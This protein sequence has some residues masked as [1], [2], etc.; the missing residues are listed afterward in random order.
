[1]IDYRKILRLLYLGK[2]QRSIAR[3]VQSSRD[4]VSS[5]IETAEA[6]G[7][8]WPLADIVT[9]DDMM[10]ANPKFKSKQDDIVFLRAARIV[11]RDEALTCYKFLE[12]K[13]LLREYE[14]FRNGITDDQEEPCKLPF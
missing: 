10:F 9:N 12:H 8:S 5:T 7:V 6:A 3:E 4:T 14:M 2:S 13:S 1:M 11:L